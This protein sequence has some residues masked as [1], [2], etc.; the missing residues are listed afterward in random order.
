MAVAC[1]HCNNML[2]NPQTDLKLT[3]PEIRGTS[4]KLPWFALQ[5]RVRYEEGV[6]DH[7]EGK[8]YELFLPLYKCRKRWSDRVKEVEA[9]L[10]PGYLFCRL[11]PQDR[12][13]ILKTPGMIQIVGSNRIPTAVDEE[14]IRA[15]QAMVASGIPN[16]PWPFLATGDR[17]RIESGPLNGLEGILVEFK[18]NHRLVLSVTLLQRSVAV[19][20]DS[21]FVSSMR[22]CSG[23][24]VEREASQG[25]AVPLAV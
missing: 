14:E 23:P 1:I 7:L 10:F 20:I 15:I 18:G 5:V 21:A 25:R 4:I 6:A 11:N 9:P 22:S 13:P 19:E 2:P 3:T 17:V 12:L 16:H 24:R 8:G